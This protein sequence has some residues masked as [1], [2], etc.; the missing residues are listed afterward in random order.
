MQMSSVLK[1]R[2]AKIKKHWCAR[3]ADA[4]LPCPPPLLAAPLAAFAFVVVPR[5]PSHW[6]HGV[7]CSV[8]VC[9]QAEEAA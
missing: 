7:C 3:A 6:R 5:L 1:K 9:T 8:W 2:R 4:A